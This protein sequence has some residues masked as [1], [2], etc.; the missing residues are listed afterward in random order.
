MINKLTIDGVIGHSSKKKITN[1]RIKWRYFYYPDRNLWVSKKMHLLLRISI[2]YSALELIL[3][4]WKRIWGNLSLLAYVSRL[5]LCLKL[6]VKDYGKDLWS[7]W[8]DWTIW[9][10]VLSK[11]LMVVYCKDFYSCSK[12]D[13][14]TGKFWK[15]EEHNIEIKHNLNLKWR[16]HH[17]GTN[18]EAGKEYL[19]YAGK[20]W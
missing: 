17:R 12:W 20:S 11:G 1:L 16:I 9:S 5:L 19:N 15:T 14:V 4:Q 6:T 13:V 18:S 3:M 7:T 2:F 10:F 8:D